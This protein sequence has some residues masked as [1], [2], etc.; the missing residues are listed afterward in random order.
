MVAQ[1]AK[2][3]KD[4]TNKHP[5]GGG[6]KPKVDKLQA[7]AMRNS[8]CSLATIAR[9]QGVTTQSIYKNL[10]TLP[11]LI[12]FRQ[13]KDT[14]FESLQ[15]EIAKTIDIDTIKAAPL[16][17][18]VT[19]MGILEDKTRLIR[20]QATGNINVLVGYIQDLQRGDE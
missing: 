17:A 2:P 4:P 8:G 13:H 10:L 16:L 18:R 14:A 3:T 12:D 11:E 5:R 1:Q 9:A 6:R 20:G 7:V 19:A 15:H